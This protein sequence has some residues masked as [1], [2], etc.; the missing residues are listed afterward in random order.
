MARKRYF[1]TEEVLRELAMD[2]GSDM[3]PEDDDFLP[4]GYDFVAESSG[5]AMLYKPVFVPFHEKRSG[6]CLFSKLSPFS[7]WPLFLLP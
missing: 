6:K 7:T 2:S 5:E 1:T 4:D 3:E